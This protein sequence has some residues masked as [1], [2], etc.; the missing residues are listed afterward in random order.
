MLTMDD[1]S[2]L[3]I[4]EMST[5]QFC[6]G[7]SGKRPNFPA[8]F[9]GINRKIKKLWMKNDF[10]LSIAQNQLQKGIQRVFFAV[11]DFWSGGWAPERWMGGALPTDVQSSP[12]NYFLNILFNENENLRILHFL[13]SIL[14]F[15]FCNIVICGTLY[16]QVWFYDTAL[17]QAQRDS[18]VI[19]FLSKQNVSSSP[20][21]TTT[22][23]SPPLKEATER[24]FT[25]LWFLWNTFQRNPATKCIG[26][27]IR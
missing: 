17:A 25:A 16:S 9:A 10:P 26:E 2:S 11:E 7:N 3:Q 15:N 5:N 23:T 27:S 19:P 18:A 13:L 14:K 22:T 24:N 21:T 12:W 20:T 8:R 1:F 6:V 4:L